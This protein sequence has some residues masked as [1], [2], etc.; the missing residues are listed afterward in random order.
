LVV[1]LVAQ[2]VEAVEQLEQLV[3]VVA[4]AGQLVLVVEQFAQ[5]VAGERSSAEE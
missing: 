3:L 5:L 1:V 4:L 2:L